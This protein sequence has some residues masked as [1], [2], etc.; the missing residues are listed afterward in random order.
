MS[1]SGL[2]M[3]LIHMPN[4]CE[5]AYTFTNISHTHT[6]LKGKAKAQC[7]SLQRLSQAGAGGLKKGLRIGRMR[8]GVIL[9]IM[10]N[11]II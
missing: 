2:Y 3:Y 9:H 8:H 11:N 1:A 4:T 6:P 7:L 10:Y 5:D